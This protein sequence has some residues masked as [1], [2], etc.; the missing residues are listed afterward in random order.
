[1]NC[2]PYYMLMS[3]KE[4]LFESMVQKIIDDGYAVSEDFIPPDIMD[5]LQKHLFALIG[6]DQM[7]SAGIGQQGN[8]HK[9]SD[10]RRDTIHWMNEFSIDAAEQF[11]FKRLTELMGYLNQTCYTGLNAL[12]CH[13]ALYDTGS[14]YKRHRDRFS[15]NSGR[16]YS[17][18]TY[19]NSDWV[20]HDGGQ[21]VLFHQGQEIFIDPVGGRAVFFES[22]KIEHE[23]LAAIRPRMSIAGWLKRI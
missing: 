13:Y 1:M 11:Y 6:D 18:I 16:K 5:A 12:E 4:E 10:I 7:N 23:V 20:P 3:D 9:N 19:L 8:F 17:I 22:D 21:L 2:G 15:G 14:F